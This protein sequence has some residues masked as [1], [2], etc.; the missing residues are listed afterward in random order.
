MSTRRP[1]SPTGSARAAT[2]TR[3]RARTAT[4]TAP[5]PARTATETAPS[6]ARTG[7]GTGAATMSTE[8]A[9]VRIRHGNSSRRFAT[10]HAGTAIPSPRA[11]AS[12]R[13]SSKRSTPRMD[14]RREAHGR[15]LGPHPADVVAGQ[16]DCAT[17]YAARRW[18][19]MYPHSRAR[20]RGKRPK[21]ATLQ[22]SAPR[23]GG[24]AATR[25]TARR[26]VAATKR[27]IHRELLEPADDSR[28]MISVV[29]VT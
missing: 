4:E 15:S 27:G 20:H 28:R 5:S 12:R 25:P 14:G 24:D 3:R 11:G 2:R 9:A 17:P 8:M 19:R 21:T 18:E 29:E 10:G 7:T 13:T 26:G 6:P 16:R 1:S 22:T 23:I